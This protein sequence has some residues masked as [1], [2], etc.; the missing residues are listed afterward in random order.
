M[1]F[2][3]EMQM[4]KIPIHVVIVTNFSRKTYIEVCVC[5]C[6]IQDSY[7]K[8]TLDAHL[9]AKSFFP[10]PRHE[11]NLFLKLSIHLQLQGCQIPITPKWN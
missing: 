4:F 9:E 2:Q 5:V 1:Q 6:F 8:Y 7:M 3:K 11:S 10:N